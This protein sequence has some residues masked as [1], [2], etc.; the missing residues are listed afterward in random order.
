LETW[1][2]RTWEIASTCWRATCIRAPS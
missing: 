1:R 2:M